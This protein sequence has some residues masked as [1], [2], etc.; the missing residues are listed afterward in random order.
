MRSF[1][2]LFLLMSCQVHQEA[3][4][5]LKTTSTHIINGTKLSAEESDLARAGVSL[6]YGRSSCSGILISSNTI[7]SAGHCFPST[8]FKASEVK[9]YIGS[10][11]P[12]TATSRSQYEV[13]KVIIH[14]DFIKSS[15]HA[16]LAV[17]I[18]KNEVSSNHQ[19][20]D[21]FDGNEYLAIA[22]PLVVAGFSPFSKPLRN[23]IYDFFT[24]KYRHDY[25]V[26]NY[27]K[28]FFF[29]KIKN[30]L[31]RKAIIMSDAL[32]G[33]QVN[34]A[35][36]LTQISGGICSGD[37][38]GPTMASRGGKHYLVGINRAVRLANNLK[39][40]DCE[41]IS[42]STSVYFYK[43]WIDETINKNN[44]ELPTWTLPRENVNFRDKK[45]ADVLTRSFDIYFSLANPTPEFCKQITMVDVDQELKNMN[46][47]CETICGDLKGFEGQCSFLSRGNADMIKLNKSLC[48]EI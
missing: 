34:D 15:D 45:C 13:Q 25:K 10:E 47:V 24:E 14:P 1:F 20:I 27:E 33:R 29:K 44:G 6:F 8:A 28:R 43:D 4:K 7:L 9:V 16:D 40:A 36:Y 17:I 11:S 21:L 12:T 18:L 38:G 37:S 46:Q 30:L 35:I 22:E 42:I 48:Q 32:M 23:S 31:S 2:L 26:S 5:S 41:F 3:D 39:E 19:P